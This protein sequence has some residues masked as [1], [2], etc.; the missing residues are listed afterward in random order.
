MNTPTPRPDSSTVPRFALLPLAS[1]LMAAWPL[2]AYAQARPAVGN[3]QLPAPAASWRVMGSGGAWAPNLANGTAVIDQTS[4]RAIYQWQQF[5]VGKDANLTYKFNHAQG[6]ALNR[7]LGGDPSQILGRLNSTVPG[8]DGK[9]VTGGTVLLINPNGILFGKDAKVDTGALIAS[10]LNLS[11]SEFLSGFSNGITGL[12]PTF[13]HEGGAELFTDERSFVL[14]DAGAQITT[15]S[16]G[17]VFLFGKSV[18]N[19][20]SIRTPGGQ[21]VL[22]AGEEVYL[23]EPGSQKIYASEANAAIPAVRGLLVEVGGAAGLVTN[24]GHIDVPRGNATLVGMAVNQSGRI[25]ATTTVSENGSVFLLARGNTAIVTDGDGAVG[26]RARTGGVLTLG[27]GSRIEL[28]PDDGAAADGKP[29]TI[30]GNATFTAS[31]VELS[32]AQI[33]LADNAS[34]KAPGGIVNLRAEVTPDYSAGDATRVGA[35]LARIAIGSGVTIDVSGT[36]DTQA[37]VERHFVTTELLGGSDLADSPLQRNGPLYRSKVTFD[38]R[39]D[40]PILSA[41]SVSAYRNSIRTMVNER[42]A[43][44][45][46]VHLQAEGDVVMH[47]SASIDVS[48][49]KVTYA[50]GAVQPTMLVAADGTRYSLND[51][52]KDI[53]YADIEGAAKGM[54]DRWGVVPNWTPQRSRIEQ[55]YVEGTAAGRI[56]VLARDVVLDGTLKADTV[57][58]ERQSAGIDPLAAGGVLRLGRSARGSAAFGD[59]FG[60][61]V[62]GNLRIAATRES[63]GSEFWGDPLAM[64]AVLAPRSGR[65]AAQTL[66]EAG[67]AEVSITSTGAIRQDAGAS[68]RLPTKGVLNLRSTG[69][70]GIVLQAGI[71]GTGA[72]VLA[73]T[74]NGGGSQ[75]RGD[76]VLGKESSID[77]SGNWVNR[78]LESSAVPGA[79]AGGSVQILSGHGLDLAEGSRID[80]SGGATVSTAGA[81]AGTAA[82]RIVLESNRSVGLTTDEVAPTKIAATLAG[83]SMQQGGS[84]RL[85][86]AGVDVVRA[87]TGTPLRPGALPGTL[88]L[89]DAFFTQGGFGSYDIEGAARLTVYNGA[90]VAPRMDNWVAPRNAATVASGV[91][92]SVLM[93]TERLPDSLRR[94]TNVTLSSGGLQLDGEPSGV[95][96]LAE[97]A[98]IDADAGA[99]VRL[100]ANA[101]LHVAGDI[102]ARGGEVNLALAGRGSLGLTEITGFNGSFDITSTARIDTSGTSIVAPTTDGTRQGKVLGGGAINIIVSDTPSSSRQTEVRIAEG[103]QLKADAASDQFA[104]NVLTRSGTRLRNET[105]QGAAGSINITAQEGGA[106]IEGSLST[107]AASAQQPGGTVSIRQGTKL[108]PAINGGVDEFSIRVSAGAVPATSPAPGS[109]LVSAKTLNDAGAGTLSLNSPHRIDFDGAVQLQ[110]QREVGITAMVVSTAPGADV[111]VAAPVVRIG[112]PSHEDKRTYSATG[113]DGRLVLAGNLVTLA[114]EQSLQGIG[115]FTA[116]A[117]SRIEL[118]GLPFGTTQRDGALHSAADLTFAAPQTTVASAA[119]YTI[120]AAGKSVSFTEGRASS[121]PVLSAAGSITVNADTITQDGVVRAPFGS[122]TLN[123]ND[124]FLGRASVTSVSGEGLVVPFGATSGGAEWNYLGLAQSRLPEKSIRLLTPGG[125]VAVSE[126]AVVDMKGGGK[127]QALEF[128]PGPGGSKDAFTGQGDGSFAILPAVGDHAVFDAHIASLSGA[129]EPAAAAQSGRTVTFGEGGPIPA[130]TYAVLPARYALLPGAFLVTPNGGA[131]VDAGVVQSRQGGSKLVGGAMGVAGTGAQSPSAGFIVR[132]SAQA[133]ALSE[134]RVTDV[135]VLVAQD[136]QRAGREVPRLAQDAGSLDLSAR[137][138]T[139]AGSFRFDPA[140][141]SIGQQAARG[142]GVGI[143]TDRLEIGDGAASSADTLRLSPAQLNAFGAQSITLGALRRQTDTG[144]VLDVGANSVKVDRSATALA[145]GDIVIAAHQQ[146]D[147]GAGAALHSTGSTKAA[148]LALAGDGALLR[149]TGDAN[150]QTQ[151]TGAIQ[152]A[153]QITLGSGSDI[154]GASVAIE[155]TAGTTIAEGAGLTAQ[156]FLVA[157]PRIAVGSADAGTGSG[158]LLVTASLADRLGTAEGLTLRSFG[159]IDFGADARLGDASLGALTLD[160]GTLRLTVP[161]TTVTVRAGDIRLTNTSGAVAAMEIGTGRLELAATGAAG[162]LVLGP[163]DV[164]L[165]G[166]MHASLAAA[167]SVVLHGR[168]SLDASGD[169]TLRGNTLT[170][171][172]G[173]QSRI[174]GATT[175]ALVLD[176]PNGT[177]DSGPRADGGAGATVQLRGQKI[178]QA[179]TVDLRSG[180]LDVHA[181]GAGVS[182]PAVEFADGSVTDLRGR[183]YVFDGQAV[184]TAGGTLKVRAEAGDI[185]LV[186]PAII[187][188]SAGGNGARAGEVNLSATNGRLTIDSTLRANSQRLPG[189]GG[190]LKLDSRTAFNLDQLAGQIEGGRV[191]AMENFGQRIEVRNREGDQ[192]LAAPTHLA[193]E[194]LVLQSDT[195]SL[196]IRGT[197]DA[198][199]RQGGVV[200]LSAGAS[201][202]V[203]AGSSLRARAEATGYRGGEVRIDSVAGRIAVQPGSQ[204]DTSSSTGVASGSLLLRARREGIDTP[205]SAGTDVRIDAIGGDIAKVARVEVEAVKTYSATNVN[206]A[207]VKTIHADNA[208]FTGADGAQAAVVVQRLAGGDAALA[209]KLHLRAGV[210]V[211]S[212]GN[213]T[214]TGDSATAGWNLATFDADGRLARAGGEP[215]NLTLR[216]AGNLVVQASISDGFRAAGSTAPTTADAADDIK[217]LA[218][219]EGEG[220]RIRLVGGADLNAAGV[221]STQASEESG[222]VNIGRTRAD[223]LVRTTTG[224]IDIAAGRDVNLVNNTA[225]VYTT[226]L[227]LDASRTPGYSAPPVTSGVTIASGAYKQPAMSS[228]GG[229]I[230]VSASRDVALGQS[231][232]Q[233]GT[234]WWWRGFNADTGGISWFTR[235]DLFKQGFGALGGGDVSVAA[236]RDAVKVQASSAPVGYVGKLEDGTRV[237]RQV[238]SGRV[239]L[240]SG[241][242]IVD[243]FVFAGGDSAMVRAGRDLAQTPTDSSG[244]AMQ[245]HFADTDVRIGAGR[246]LDLGAASQA[247]LLAAVDQWASSPRATFRNLLSGLA[248]NASLHVVSDSGDVRL[249]GKRESFPQNPHLGSGMYVDSKASNVIPATAAIAAPE[250][251][252][253]FGLGLD[254]MQAPAER[255]S[256][257]VAARDDVFKG[258]TNLLV[259]GANEI[260]ASVHSIADG[261]AFYSNPFAAGTTAMQTGGVQP[262]RIVSSHGSIVHRGE[263]ALATPLRMIAGGDIVQPEG[264]RIE[265]QHTRATDLSLIQ[266]GGDIRLTRSAVV[267]DATIKVHGPGDLVVMAGR[268]VDLGASGGVAAAGNRQNA[269]LPDRSAGITVLPGVAFDRGDYVEAVARYVHLLG[270]NGLAAHAGNLAA[271][272][273]AVSAGAAPP[274][275]GSAGNEAWKALTPAQR[276]ARA[277]ELAG[278]ESFDSSLLA[279]MRVRSGDPAMTLAGAKAKLPDLDP[280]TVASL[281]AHIVTDRWMALTA[282]EQWVRT[283]IELAGGKAYTSA[284]A[285]FVEAQ[286][287]QRPA[288]SAAALQ[289]FAELAPERQLL[290]LN[291]VLGNELRA[292]GRAASQLSGE[293]RAAAYQVGYDALDALFAVRGAAANAEMGASQIKTLQ[294][295]PI[296]ILAPRG[297]IN[298]GA[299]TA[300]SSTKGASELG[301]VTTAGGAVTLAVK[302]DVAVNRSRVFTVGK[303]DLLIWASEGD[304]DAG[305]GAKTVTGAPPPVYRVVEGRVVV[306]TSSSYAGSGIA[307]LDAGS[308]LD[309]YAPKGEINAGD[310][311]IKSAGNAFLGAARFVGADNLQVGGVA[312]GAPPPAPSAGGTAGLAAAGQSATAAV[313]AAGNEDDEEERRRKRRQR[314]DLMLDFLG[315]GERS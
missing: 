233:Y 8:A 89:T 84:L 286:T 121:A 3:L 28:A 25:S 246:H 260:Q 128:V 30:D 152:A 77:V 195:G 108:N 52:S 66:N 296:T 130:G 51:A 210:E 78:T 249:Y 281:A 35:G 312:V 115:Q 228:G 201:V 295:S 188:V 151:R 37:S 9:A 160:A 65:I 243:G 234:H 143:S 1:A 251:A 285:Q 271:Q 191:A 199:G 265:F 44:G 172:Q 70:E 232:T 166:T 208:A 136:A 258:T 144:T 71:S 120:D 273:E 161:D 165:A 107:R 100:S 186:D 95:L 57:K 305:R 313:N 226:G 49:G 255:S 290:H 76:I 268:D 18:R 111:S 90:T 275:A 276:L 68:L 299:L 80:V 88:T 59:G 202:T 192:V 132:T 36:T 307:V 170:A 262:T 153:G 105:V 272:L 311:G 190:T 74:A 291:A 33:S 182:G 39:R 179:G 4:Q 10:T 240:T 270:G 27:A 106:R 38:T 227:P 60:D 204:F 284:L 198:S 138:L 118:Q 277:S 289:A 217:P 133:Q 252:A 241:R 303:G 159:S 197:L 92:P 140:S 301:I 93:R 40:A 16:G 5:N 141:D 96:T 279:F 64:T 139:V 193:A 63:M 164:A 20:G 56:N 196:D 87:D 221:L 72:S 29:L 180:T 47:E 21:T 207:L 309:L 206:A 224:S 215:M 13:K 253:S 119:R 97:G 11:D 278:G 214:V 23:A 209:S 102:D 213:L 163:G 19:D 86:A 282:P 154:R 34:I 266:A 280:T 274:A 112:A 306:D 264:Q 147:I 287:G 41:D 148:S 134:I 248:P 256:L 146:V 223:V 83:H 244:Y 219:A 269:A 283:A 187:D 230:N 14:V 184:A 171:R 101:R 149:V 125:R 116:A 220:G 12:A 135:D 194:R 158:A 200:D 110:A 297:S 145:A 229:S 174:G 55:G 288:D 99:N 48:G 75:Q 45:G 225:V 124:I 267:S 298:V 181:T 62:L 67:F 236:G 117:G 31:R 247:G 42:M 175:G 142:G 292:A 185:R 150:A 81:V 114:G 242:D 91:T 155:S 169:L 54:Q 162:D 261:S 314:R 79:V 315:F 85:R 183:S 157:A 69:E 176:R 259:Q 46:T 178:V 61:A 308:T 156:Q 263:T 98:R 167:R 94:A 245:V 129:S 123:A 239:S 300:S 254:L 212:A 131:R 222:D 173:A 17:R 127:V 211:R 6:S 235:Y 302:D 218:T 50:A 15:A 304:I 26:K 231:P 237:Q 53:V 238:A 168:G 32:G 216:A 103:A 7:V 257:L 2:M 58:G 293:E 22:G 310:A 203:A 189:L 122:I 43:K 73:Q 82:G 250:G 205:K 137:Q 177:D 113:G 109:V 104:V 24:N 294:G 126:G